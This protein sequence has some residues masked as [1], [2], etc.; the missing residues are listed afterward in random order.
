MSMGLDAVKFFPAELNGGVAKLKACSGPYRN[1]KWMCTGGISAQNLREY[2]AF[3][4]VLAVGGTWMCKNEDIRA[5]AWDKIAVLSRE[6]V[7]TMLAFKLA[8]IG[9]NSANADEAAAMAALLGE[10]LGKTVCNESSSLFVGEREIEIM[11]QPGRGRNG[12]IAVQCSN[13]D[14]AI[15][16]LGLRGVKIDKSSMVTKN[17]KHI[18]CYL[19]G[20]IGGFAIHIVEKTPSSALQ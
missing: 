6:A 7:N 9:I 12:H 15:Y 19:D 18:A 2:L 4:K 5:G 14:R 11:K 20:E 3:D 13:V 10:M 1:L 8:H 17:G 16:H